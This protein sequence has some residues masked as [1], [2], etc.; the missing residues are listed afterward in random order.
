M[1]KQIPTKPLAWGFEYLMNLLIVWMILFKCQNSGTKK[2][3]K[4][5]EVS[6]SQWDDWLQKNNEVGVI[7][8]H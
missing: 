8:V 4:K 5:S 1:K 3:S 6:D 7:K 2:G